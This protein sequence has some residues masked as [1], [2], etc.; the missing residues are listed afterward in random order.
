MKT[1]ICNNCGA[2]GGD[3]YGFC[4]HCTPNEYMDYYFTKIP[5]VHKKSEEIKYDIDHYEEYV[6]VRQLY[7]KHIPKKSDIKKLKI[8]TKSWLTRLYNKAL[9]EEEHKDQQCI[10]RIL[11]KHAKKLAIEFGHYDFLSIEIPKH[12][13]YKEFKLTKSV[14]LYKYYT[15]KVKPE[16]EHMSDYIRHNAFLQ[17]KEGDVKDIISRTYGIELPRGCFIPIHL[18]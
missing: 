1:P 10:C 16:A 2:V 15:T 6:K 3:G 13:R 14:S 9:D 8:Y 12:K 18:T 4:R 7:N 11:M 5:N 17:G